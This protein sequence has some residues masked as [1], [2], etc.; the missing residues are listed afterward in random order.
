MGHLLWEHELRAFAYLAGRSART[1]ALSQKAGIVDLPS[2][3]AMGLLEPLKAEF[4]NGQAPVL[5]R[6]EGSL[7]GV[8]ARSRR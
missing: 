4:Q 8:L 1:W 2:L 6:M 3:E 7:A 5:K